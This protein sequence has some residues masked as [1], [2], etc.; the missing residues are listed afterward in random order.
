MFKIRRIMAEDFQ[1]MGQIIL[2]MKQAS[3]NFNGEAM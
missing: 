1:M 2:A 3:L